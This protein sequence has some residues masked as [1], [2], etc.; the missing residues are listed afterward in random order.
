MKKLFVGILAAVLAISAGTVSVSA[1]GTGY[2]KNFG[3]GYANKTNSICNF[4]RPSVDTDGDGICDICGTVGNGYGYGFV[5]ENG[6]GVCD[7]GTGTRPQDGSGLKKG[8][9]GGRS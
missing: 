2:G 8:F 7:Y 6:D 9:R 5:D 4:L 3:K 1:A